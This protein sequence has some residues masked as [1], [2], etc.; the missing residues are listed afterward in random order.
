MMK[1]LIHTLLI[2]ETGNWLL[3]EK[4]YFLESITEPDWDNHVF[5]VDL[6]N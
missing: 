4:Y 5:P 3:A 2:V 6:T 1:V